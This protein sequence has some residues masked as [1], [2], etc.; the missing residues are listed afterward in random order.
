MKRL[1]LALLV[2]SAVFP[3]FAG[4]VKSSSNAKME[5]SQDPVNGETVGDPVGLADGAVYDAATDLR[6]ACPGMDLVF[7]RSYGSWAQRMGPLG[8]GWTHSYDWRIE[9][10]SSE[11]CVFSAGETGVTDGV[12]RFAPVDPG[13]SVVNDEGYELRR[14]G[15]GL[16]SVVTPHGLGYFFGS[17]R[18]LCRIEAWNGASVTLT[19]GGKLKSVVRAEHS[20][21]KSIAFELDEDGCIWKAVSPDPSVWAEYVYSTYGED[22]AYRVKQLVGVIRHDGGRE[23]EYRYEY[24]PILRPKNL[25]ELTRVL[26]RDRQMGIYRAG[27]MSASNSRYRNLFLV[28]LVLSRKTDPNGLI[29]DYA[30][31]GT[32]RGG[33]GVQCIE[34]KMTGGLFACYMRYDKDRTRVRRET[35]FGDVEEWACF[36]DRS[37]EIERTVG[38][39][40]RSKTYDSR[41]DLAGVVSMNRAT[42]H[43]LTVA[44]GYDGRHRVV[45]AA[46][47][48]DAAPSLWWAFGWDDLSGSIRRVASPCGRVSEWVRG[49]ESYTVYGAGTSD[50]RLVSSVACDARWRPVSVLDPDG[51][52]TRFSY[53]ADGLVSRVEADGLPAV[54]VGYDALGNMSSMSLPGP[55]GTGRAVSMS[56]N[57]KGRPLSV[58][59]PDGTA[60]SFA[61]DGSGTKVVRHVDQLGREDAYKWVLGLPVHAGRVVGGVTN[62]LFGVGHDKQLNVVSITDPLG[63]KAES[64]ALD[65]NDRIVAVTNLEG[66]AMTRTYALGELVA[67]ETRFDGTIVAYGYD[68]DANLS[69]IAY[70]GETLSFSYDADGLLVSAS[71]SIGVVTNLY[72][73]STGW[74]DASQGADGTWVAYARSD[75][76]AV[77]SVTSVAG[78]TAYSLDA[79]RRRTHVATP[80][81]AFDFGYCGWNGRLSVVTNGNGLVT[82]YAYD[83][84]DRVINISWITASGAAISGFA[85]EYDAVGRITSRSFTLGD[86]SQPSPMSLSSQKNYAYDDLDRLASDGDVAYTYDAAGNRMT[87]TE[88]GDT[89]TYTLGVGD[90][91]ASYGR[92]DSMNPPQGGAYTH[93]AAGNVTRIERDGRPTLDLTWNSLYQLVSVATNGVFAESYTYDALSRR[94]STTTRGGTTRH[95]YDDNWQCIADIDGQGNVVASYV[96]GDGIDKLLAVTIG[97]A[98]YYPLTDIQGT[99]CGYV[100]SQNNVV[101]RWQYDAW[102]NVVDEYVLTSAAALASIRY[103]F[104]G[105]EWSSATGLI[106]FRMRWYDAE[107]GRWLSKDPIGLSGGL[108]LYAF[109]GGDSVNAKDPEGCAVI[110]TRPLDSGSYGTLSLLTTW[111]VS[112][113]NLY[114]NYD[115]R[116]REIFFE[117][118][119]DSEECPS[120]IGYGPTDGGVHKDKSPLVYNNQEL[121][122]Y[123]DKLMREAASAVISTGNWTVERYNLITHNCQ[124]FV[125]AVIREYNKLEKKQRR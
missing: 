107:T 77:T 109:C 112:R 53:G 65:E 85:Y 44:C 32:S 23:S 123:N 2:L 16:Y 100:D 15:E 7:R 28:R 105:R 70:P 115:I 50:L 116:H 71:N 99:V 26:Q 73:A 84:M 8:V 5:D 79:A 1:F 93:D 33:L 46:S 86:P 97:G 55:G 124:D 42:R 98:T 102:G 62:T 120:H 38:D 24:E 57:W 61:Y 3:L 22:E 121:K 56:N 19:R 88:D 92:A 67:S 25:A 76:G 80:S 96:W 52:E 118:G 37:R 94:V 101:A 78:T 83:I 45:S 110:K 41:G 36:D 114:G 74:R 82:S 4:T 63:R 48:L 72:D 54:D 10:R 6:V 113:I 34:T 18:R 117:D 9:A 95:V 51:G 103:R 91:L 68:A 111:A 81:A 90:R 60:E 11:V 13:G 49:D 21:G 30:Y 20:D 47:A 69:S 106:N 17:D 66:Q 27:G 31:S 108:N 119:K 43:T 89:I 75:G 40:T 122:H 12:H 125:S 39:E 14:T 64:Y 87:R 29:T 35:A 59:Y 58:S 104:Q